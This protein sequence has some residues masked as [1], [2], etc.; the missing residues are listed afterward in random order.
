MAKPS[1]FHSKLFVHEPYVKRTYRFDHLEAG[2]KETTPKAT[3]L[4]DRIEHELESVLDHRVRDLIV[5]N[6]VPML[7]VIRKKLLAAQS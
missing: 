1:T 3:Q 5:S 6:F 4:F 2:L 7:K